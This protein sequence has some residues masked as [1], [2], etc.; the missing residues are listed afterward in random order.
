MSR[1][2]GHPAPAVSV[3]LPTWNRAALVL[4]AVHSVLAQ[5]FRDLELIVIDDGSGDDTLA[6]L[7]TV[8]DRRLRVLPCAHRG[9]AATL[10]SG[11]AA[12]RGGCIARLDSDDIWLPELLERQVAL[13]R[14]RP[15]VG[16]VYARA[17][18]IDRQGR[19]TG[20]L[21]GGPLRV[22]D[23]AVASLLYSDPVAI[24]TALH[25]REAIER[26]G[27]YDEGLA[28]SE[29]WDMH[30]R[31]ALHAR[32]A[33]NDRVLARVRWH[34]GNSTGNE[35]RFHASRLAVLERFFARADLP[36][37]V[38]ALRAQAYSNAWAERGFEYWHRGRR[39]EALTAFRTSLRHAPRRTRALARLVWFAG[40]R[41]MLRHL[42]G[43]PFR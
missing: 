29:D 27:P 6:R 38:R 39:R 26:A 9:I 5:T 7:A 18:V 4:E 35:E 22:P 42:P 40:V 43:Y 3:L 41:P 24:I 30:L 20:E 32:F 17:Q 15:E 37:P 36:V 25:R 23:D 31:L 14:S 28:L 11:L 19:P 33:F 8:R 34:G 10:N 2:G 21:R 12:A 13:L 1:T 16:V